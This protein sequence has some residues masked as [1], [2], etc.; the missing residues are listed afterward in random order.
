VCNIL[1]SVVCQCSHSS[2]G[3]LQELDEVVSSEIFLVW[4]ILALLGQYRTTVVV[5]APRMV[6]GLQALY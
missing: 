4:S 2:C 3:A 1:L 6:G 5:L